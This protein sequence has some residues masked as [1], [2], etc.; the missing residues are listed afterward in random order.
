MPET[1]PSLWLTLSF[2]P[3]PSW[4]VGLIGSISQM[5]RLRLRAVKQLSQGH[6]TEKW[7]RDVEGFRM[8]GGGHPAGLCDGVTKECQDPWRNMSPVQ[9][10]AMDRCWGWADQVEGTAPAKA[11][12]LKIPPGATVWTARGKVLGRAMGSWCGLV[13]GDQ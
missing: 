7:Q 11:L 2:N 5:R 6:A 12:R 13:L 4:K 10:P 8:K 1:K 9:A 3:H